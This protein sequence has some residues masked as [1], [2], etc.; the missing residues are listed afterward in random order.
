MDIYKLKKSLTETKNKIKDAE[1]GIDIQRSDFF[2][3]L[4]ELLIE[5]Q[6]KTD[7]KQ[8]DIIKQL[9]E[10]QNRIVHALEAP[11]SNDDDDNELPAPPPQEAIQPPPPEEPIQ[12]PSPQKP[13]QLPPQEEEEEEPQP[14]TSKKRPIIVN[15]DKGFTEK[16]KKYLNDKRFKLPSEYLNE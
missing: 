7:Q 9:R 10:N 4:R 11:F 12:P 16:G 2:K 1:S 8:E 13:I 14:S 3:T 6:K 15:L 5:Q